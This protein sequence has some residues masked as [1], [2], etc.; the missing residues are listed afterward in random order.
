MGMQ[1]VARLFLKDAV[2]DNISLEGMAERWRQLEQ[3]LMAFEDL[4]EEQLRMAQANVEEH[5]MKVS[6][7]W[8][9]K[10]GVLVTTQVGPRGVTQVPSADSGSPGAIR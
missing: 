1:E 10:V 8:D 7:L 2:V 9:G 5:R 6:G 4:S 3:G